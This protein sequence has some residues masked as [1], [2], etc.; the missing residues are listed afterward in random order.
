MP[1]LD[2]APIPAKKVNGIEITNAHGHDTTRKLS[3]RYTHVD[4]SPVTAPGI[5]AN[6]NATATTA[7]V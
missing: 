6:S 5:T 3:A 2:A 1:C 7:G 4:H